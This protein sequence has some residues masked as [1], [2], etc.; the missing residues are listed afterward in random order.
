MKTKKFEKKLVLNKST[1][2]DLHNK[3]MQFAVGGLKECLSTS[4]PGC[5]FSE[6]PHACS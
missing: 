3:E 4:T 6:C 2:A 5:G 1:I